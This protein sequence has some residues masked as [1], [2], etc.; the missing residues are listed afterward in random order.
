MNQLVFSACNPSVKLTFCFPLHF[1]VHLQTMHYIAAYY[2]L[3]LIGPR[4]S[5]HYDLIIFFF[6]FFFVPRAIDSP[7]IL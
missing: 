3:F 2:Q 7:Y 6:V 1:L 4:T 5:S